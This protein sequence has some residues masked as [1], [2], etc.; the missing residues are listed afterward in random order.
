MK[1]L[2]GLKELIENNYNLEI[3][4]DNN[5][6]WIKSGDFSILIEKYDDGRIYFYASNDYSKKDKKIFEDFFVDCNESVLYALY[7][8][9]KNYHR[10]GEL[11]LN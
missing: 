6:L 5:R 4:E 2:E 10:W 9:C 8:Y 3:V 1:K 11:N 7:K